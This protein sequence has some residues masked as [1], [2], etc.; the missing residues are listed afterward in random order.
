MIGSRLH[1]FQELTPL[2]KSGANKIKH[3]A[4]NGEHFLAIA[5][6]IE[7]H[8]YITNSHIYK[9][10]GNKFVLFQSI[11]T[12]GA[13]DIT[14]FKIKND[15]FLCIANSNNG[16]TMMIDSEI[17]KFVSGKFHS[18]KKISTAGASACEAFS[19]DGKYF[20]MFGNSFYNVLRPSSPSN[21]YRWENNGFVFV[22]SIDTYAVQ[23]VHYLK[24]KGQHFLVCANHY[25]SNFGY[26]F[27]INSF[28]FKWNGAQFVLFQNIK[29]YGATSVTSFQISGETYLAFANQRRTQM[30]YKIHTAV[31][32]A[33]G[34][35]FSYY[36]GLLDTV[37]AFGVDGF[38]YHGQPYLAVVSYTNGMKYKVNSLLYQCV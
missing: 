3:F 37:G 2:P 22:Q 29:T 26:Q 14:Y 25:N 28:I 6:E 21:I 4:M 13:K 24:V 30:N 18:F 35:G 11:A 7:N 16:F 34:P 20:I 8:S 31:Y 32:K 12:Y 9:W 5:V 36:Q 17:M 23:D 38:V 1:R 10:N 27:E 33:T 19:I 15:H